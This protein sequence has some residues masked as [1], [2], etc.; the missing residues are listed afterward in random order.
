MT[1]ATARIPANGSTVRYSVA[2]GR[3]KRKLEMNRFRPSG[4]MQYASSRLRMKI[5]P[6]WNGDIV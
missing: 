4:G 6:S 5:I 3:L 2:T 1:S